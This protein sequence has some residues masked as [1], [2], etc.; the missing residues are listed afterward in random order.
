M[1]LR[2]LS[3]LVT[4]V[5]HSAAASSDL[6]RIAWTDD[7]ST[8]ATL[9]WRL[10]SGDTPNV[11]YGT[12]ADGSN[13][14]THPADEATV[15]AHPD[16]A[17][18]SI[19]LTTQLAYLNGLS[20]D[21]AYYFQICDSE[22]CSDT[23]W[24]K[25]APNI[26]GNFTFIAGGDSRT[27]R[28][29]RQE[30][31]KLVAASRP[32]F[33][34][35]NGDFTDDG[36]HEQ[37]VDWL[38]DWQL[39]R[40]EDGRM[41][42]IVATHGNHENDVYD[43]LSYVFGVP[44]SAYYKLSIGG[45]M[46]DIFSL[47]SE[48]EP[49]VGYGAYDDQNADAWNAQN[50][51]FTTD[52]A[53]SSASW[54]LA[55]YHR[56]MRPHTSGKSEGTG[57][58]EAW[59]EIFN[60]QDFQLIVESD[61]H[62]AKYTYPVIYSQAAGSYQDFIRDDANGSMIIGEGSWGAPTRPTDDDKPWT[63]DSGS[64]WQ[65]KLIHAAPDNMRIHTVRFGSEHETLAGKAFS[66]DTVTP[67]TQATQDANAVAVAEGLPL[68]APLSGEALD[69]PLSGFVGAEIDNVQLIGAGSSWKYL[70]D[71][72]SPADWHIASFDD[73]AW[74]EAPAQLGYGD[75]DEVTEID[76]GGDSDNKHIT[77]YF[78]HDFNF[79]SSQDVIKL[80]LRLLR[81]DGAIVYL[82][83]SEV[84]RSNMP[85]GEVTSST[86]ASSGIGGSAEQSFYEYALLPEQLIVGE[87]TLAVEVHQ[88]D[89]GSS[90]LS[91]DVDLTAVI[92]N[93]D[94]TPADSTTT[95]EATPLSIS[96]IE[97][98]W[99]D[100]ASFDEVGYQLERRVGQGE[101]QVLTWRIDADESSYTDA[102]LIEG[103]SYSYRIRPYNAAGLSSYSADVTAET[104]SNPVPRIFSEDFELGDLG[105]MLA[106]NV[107]SD[108]EW[109]ISTNGNYAYM[110][111]YGADMES[112][113]WLITPS[114]NLGY[115]SETSLSFESAYNYDG[116][117]LELSYS[118][119]YDPA[120]HNS[121]LDA[122]WVVIPECTAANG[123]ACW[124]QPS[125]AQW[126]FEA[127]T[128]DLSAV[129]AEQVSFAFR[130]T[131][132]GTGGGDGRGWQV[133]NIAVRGNYQGSAVVSDSLETG[134]P[135]TWT[136]HSS[137]STANWDA[138]VQLDTPGVFINGFGADEASNDWLILPAATLS[139]DD[140]A[141]LSFDYYQ[142]YSGPALKVMASTNYQDGNEPA[143]A[144]WT[145]LNVALPSLHE[146]WAS[147]GPISLAA[148][149][150]NVHLAF[151]YTTTGTG[152]GD[153]A[154]MGLANIS[155]NRNLDG[156]VTE[157]EQ[158][159]ENFDALD[160]FGSFSSYSASSNADWVIEER[161]GQTGA[162]ISGFGADAASDD[163]LISP[164]VEL[165]SWHNGVVDFDIY[166]NYGGPALSV[167]ISNDYSGSG[168]PAA[169]TWTELSY[170]DDE[171]STPTALAAVDDAWTSYRVDLSSYTGTA[172][173]AFRYTSTGTGSGEGR[174]L[175][176]DN[177]SYKSTYGEAGMSAIFA[178]ADDVVASG[179]DANF[180]ATVTNGTAPYSYGWNFGD[181]NNS[182][183]ESP[184]HQ[185]A[186]AGDYSVVLTVTDAEGTVTSMTRSI[187]IYQPG[188]AI[189]ALSADVRIATFN[190]YLNRPTE[191]QILT[192]SLSGTDS[193]IANVAEI[194]QRVRPDVVLLQEFDYVADGSA[195][196][197]FKANYLEVSQ[198]GAD[199]IE[200][201]FV[202]LAE[203]NTGIPSEF[204]FDND[205]DVG[206]LG[207]GGDA[208][209]FGEFPGQYGMVLLSR[210]PIVTDQ[211]R[212]F[213]HFLWKDMPDAMLPINP[214]TSEGWYSEEELEVFR[215]SSKS[216]WDVPIDVNGNI[217]HVLASHPTPPVFDGDED[218]NG[219]RNHDE[220]RFWRD[221][222]D[223]SLA[224][225]IYDDQGATGGLAD[226]QSF[227]IMGDQ[228][229]SLHEGDA[230][231]DPISMLTNSSLINSADIPTS[232]GGV[233]NTP[234]SE[235]AAR[236][237]ADWAIQVDYVLPSVAGIEVDHTA[238]FWPGLAD[239]LYYLVG[240]GVA[241]SDHRLVY[242]D[243][244]LGVTNSDDSDDDGL[245][246]SAGYG[247]ILL[248]FVAGSVR[249]RRLL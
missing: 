116:P 133:D 64:F 58:I 182:S 14:T 214:D 114:I 43:M 150:G 44:N 227:V 184:A 103:E 156:V 232:I 121:P 162:L 131:S 212:T 68:W 160:N 154:N 216:H 136:N 221:Y 161:S 40:S 10:V 158:L 228:N 31:N 46:L 7:P 126:T 90:D 226:G 81:D 71:G 199:P 164:A 57:R 107:T 242:L 47:N 100:D 21:T 52:S 132:T 147:I 89:A 59:A 91:F 102:K 223:P 243:A 249:R 30:G 23:S 207:D 240:P 195:V 4:G 111:G 176:V 191:G 105:Q 193:Q 115:Y 16:D 142:K 220:I 63:M 32:L 208:Y 61:T 167:L 50:T 219:L 204:D 143:S 39:S 145:D 41:Y 174:R 94:A 173:L 67:L 203:S 113:D 119:D 144:D 26:A 152:P 65:F 125:E 76:F 205:G 209:G 53:A 217:V 233:E 159:G 73:S 245:F 180:V 241:S 210:Y 37:W 97:L 106:V 24:F 183:D 181:G 38:T 1:K 197:A 122:T 82:N 130:Y 66:A 35:F 229:A 222:I 202:Y 77:S 137:A 230:T 163:W 189:P 215:L 8:T 34:L 3:L 194:L 177:F 96:E 49:G 83:G 13:W 17:V 80:T 87:N 60:Q 117:L 112:D 140:L 18:D 98:S 92:S 101:W 62:M 9:G 127:T 206:G 135:T 196:A 78:R 246:G 248:A 244:N 179:E 168:D 201:P 22:G 213:Q 29:P 234:S 200:Y 84:V 85:E 166:T 120:V 5:C 69:L 128:V 12:A 45:N 54:K 95:L 235:Y 153:G 79:N 224:G 157:N 48:A 104:L 231:N 190:A 20:A 238:V 124:A 186:E 99:N 151:V 27:N 56:P 141:S 19:T 70:D 239:E 138:G 237:T 11:R 33:V 146:A 36:N 225:Y 192:D 108:A 42:P 155:I 171:P 93:I 15:M 170:L 6:P 88:S 129:D 187:T 218:R 28:Q 75:G 198:N 25:T 172:Y 211:V 109:G 165:L 86:P 134:V 139:E 2:L 149:L 178:L 185:Y 72:S 236:H 55:N 148:Y 118:L 110:N 123:A 51:A 175:G 188:Q 74:P 247:L 169:A